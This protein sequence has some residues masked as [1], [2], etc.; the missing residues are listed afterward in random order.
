MK[1]VLILFAAAMVSYVAN[2]QFYAGGAVGLQT[3]D[4]SSLTIAPEAG[5]NLNDDFSVGAVVGFINET[6]KAG[7]FKNTTSE[8]LIN[9]YVRWNF[10][11][12]APVQ[13]FLDGSFEFSSVSTSIKQGDNKDSKTYSCMRLGIKPGISIPVNEKLSFVGH[14][15]FVGFASVDDD[16]AGYRYEDGL[17]VELSGNAILM[18]LYYKF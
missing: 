4:R 3:G 11:E 14:L 8:L 5:Y 1:K 16:L 17:C 7:E 9:P 10:M 12:W 13:F 6:S 18:G 15:G 2:A